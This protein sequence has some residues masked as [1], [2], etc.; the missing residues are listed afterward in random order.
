MNLFLYP[1]DQFGVVWA[2][3]Y[4]LPWSME[5]LL[6]TY[7]ASIVVIYQL[8]AILFSHMNENRHASGMKHLF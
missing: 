6:E 5:I 2:S 1:F 3:F 4:G 7:D 8:W